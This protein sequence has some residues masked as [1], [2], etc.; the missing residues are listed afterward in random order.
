MPGGLTSR[1]RSRL[2]QFYGASGLGGSFEAYLAKLETEDQVLVPEKEHRPVISDSLPAYSGSSACKMCHADVYERWSHTGMARMLQPYQAEN[3]IGDFEHKNEFFEG[4]DFGWGNGRLQIIPG[5]H[6]TLWA[7]MVL[8]GGR[9]F[10]DI[11][12]QDDSWRRYAVDYTIGSKW[13][14]GYATRLSNGDIQIFP[15]QYNKVFKVWLNY[16]QIIDSMKGPRADLHAWPLMRQSTSYQGNCALCHTSQ[17]H[18]TKGRGSGVGQI[19]F[20]EP[21]VDCEMCHGPSERHVEFML[22]GQSYDKDPLDPPVDFNKIGARDYIAICSQCHMQSAIRKPGPGGELNYSRQ[23]TFFTNYLSRPY[24]EFSRKGF[25]RD[26]RFRQ[27]TFI[28]ESLVRSECYQKGQI[29]CGNCHDPHP[30]DYASNPVSLKFRDRPNE[31]CLKCHGSLRVWGTLTAHTHH[32]A[33][34]EAS[35]CVSCHM[36]RIVDA[37]LF[38]ARTHQIDDM[39]KPAMTLRFGPGESPNA[40]LLCHHQRNADWVRAQLIA[41]KQNPSQVSKH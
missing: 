10:F 4:D 7:R 27:T 21:G 36:P 11:R 41:W 9:H 20:R 31:M 6:R 39:P 2:E 17:A 29:T 24:A 13:Q 38:R 37:L 19:E 15:I 1:A 25:Y 22:K 33:D 18:N 32:P 30:S 26:G 34:T 12:Q 14:Q 23:G 28:V 40:C 35:Q 3:V 16:W 5:S 8:A